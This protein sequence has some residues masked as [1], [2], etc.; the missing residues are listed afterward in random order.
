LLNK[1][2]SYSYIPNELN[3]NSVCVSRLVVRRERQ[4][5]TA[6]KNN[7]VVFLKLSAIIPLR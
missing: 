2:I 3:A 5:I 1:L 7:A 4:K 6:I